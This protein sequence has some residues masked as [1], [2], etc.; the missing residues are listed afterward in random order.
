MSAWSSFLSRLSVGLHS[1]NEADLDAFCGEMYKII[2][3]KGTIYIAGNGGSASTADHFQNDIQAGAS[4]HV[5]R[6]KAISMSSNAALQTTIANDL[7]YEKIFS[8]QVESM[9]EPGDG[10][11]LISA[12]GN[13]SNLLNAAL[14]AKALGVNTF[15]LLGFD[16][17]K[18][19]H[20]VD[21][22]L[23]VP[24]D[25][26]DYSVPESAH[27]IIDH[28]FMEFCRTHV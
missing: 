28:Y 20:M 23:L 19:L 24:S 15:A 21:W 6:F 2:D 1:I 3:N 26:G 8:Y 9:C 10:L 17:G 16:G 18:L 25:A 22:P 11:L 14:A 5:P 12:S 7:G 4:K 27:L 13:S